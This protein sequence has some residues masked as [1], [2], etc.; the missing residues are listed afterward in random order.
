VVDEAPFP[1]FPQPLPDVLSLFSSP[2]RPRAGDCTLREALIFGSVIA[3]TAIP[4][5]HSAAALIKLASLTPYHGAVSIFLRTL[6]NKKYTLPYLAVDALVAHFVRFHAEAVPGPLPVVWH[7]AL[8]ATAQ[9]YKADLTREQKDALRALMHTH[10]HHA[11]TPEVRRE[12]FSVGCRGD[13]VAMPVAAAAQ[14]GG[15]GAAA[16][17]GVPAAP[18]AAPPAAKKRKTGGPMDVEY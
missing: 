2:S 6:V 7:Q 12:I 16:A 11:I 15:S 5:L 18:K 14:R 3:K 13:P 1:R 8:L 10:A 4:Q 17:A 9:R